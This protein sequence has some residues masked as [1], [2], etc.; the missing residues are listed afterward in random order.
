MLRNM[1]INLGKDSY[2]KTSNKRISINYVQEH[3]KE[4]EI[5]HQL[6][7]NME[8]EEQNF[9]PSN[10]GWEETFIHYVFF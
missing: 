7:D 9:L 3:L 1:V 6:K 5:L 8:I 4:E 2:S 10:V